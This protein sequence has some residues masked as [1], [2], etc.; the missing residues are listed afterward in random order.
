MKRL[1]RWLA[2]LEDGCAALAMLVLVAVTLSVCLEVVTRYGFNRPLVWVVEYTEYGLLYITFL[3]AAWNLREGGH[4]RIEL[5]YER[6]SERAQAL[7]DVSGAFLGLAVSLVLAIFGFLATQ[8]AFARGLYRSSL[9]ETPLW[10][11]M[12]V[13]PLGGFLLTVRYLRVFAGHAARL[14]TLLR[15]QA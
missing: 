11:V 10:I 12:A 7:C 9:L 6:L 15:A 14:R 1:E 4:V 3:A 8:S 2:R 13:V 5:L